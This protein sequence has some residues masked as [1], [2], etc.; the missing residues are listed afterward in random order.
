MAGQGWSFDA[1]DHGVDYQQNGLNDF[2]NYDQTQGAI[3]ADLENAAD[4]L[5]EHW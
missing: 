2:N 4:E 5:G 1:L 3:W